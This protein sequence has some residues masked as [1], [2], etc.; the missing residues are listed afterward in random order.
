MVLFSD[1]YE[2]SAELFSLHLLSVRSRDTELANAEDTQTPDSSL[3]EESITEELISLAQKQLSIDRGLSG[4]QQAVSSLG[5]V[6]AL[7]HTSGVNVASSKRPTFE[8]IKSSSTKVLPLKLNSIPE[9]TFDR[10]VVDSALKLVLG[11]GPSKAD[12]RDVKIEDSSY[13]YLRE[14]YD[15][16]SISGRCLFRKNPPEMADI[17]EVDTTSDSRPSQVEPPRQSSTLHRVKLYVDGSWDDVAHPVQETAVIPVMVEEFVL[18]SDEESDDKDVEMLRSH[19]EGDKD[20]QDE[21]HHVRHMS[22]MGKPPISMGNIS[23]ATEDI[24]LTFVIFL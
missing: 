2:P 13:R 6:P 22:S 23:V 20:Y 3:L 17:P 12:K 24:C 15:D 8:E 4:C 10:E 19:D 14:N 11:N 16:L 1:L 18:S 5:A 7:E 9:A 21:S